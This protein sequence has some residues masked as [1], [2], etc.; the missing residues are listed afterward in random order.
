MSSLLGAPVL[1]ADLSVRQ[2]SDISAAAAAA[3]DAQ[4]ET[5]VAPVTQDIK[6]VQNNTSPKA[7]SPNEVYRNT[8]NVL[9]L[10]KEELK[11]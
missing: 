1:K 10:A 4:A 9:S 6:F 8:K 5:P 11:V 7:L 3:R 2:A